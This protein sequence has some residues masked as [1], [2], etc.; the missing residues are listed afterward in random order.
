M[1]ATHVLINI[2]G[3]IALIVWGIHM[4]Q[5]GVMRVFGSDLRRVLARGLRT[6]WHAFAA[7]LGVTTLLQ[8]STATALMAGSLAGTG[9][10]DL[11]TG[12]AIMLG[13]N[14]GTTLIV[15]VLAFDVSVVFPVFLAAGVIAFRRGGSSR[16]HDFGRVL[17][18][19]GLI[20]LALRLLG[21]TIA[22]G[23]HSAAIGSFLAAVTAEPLINLLIAALVT[24]IVAFQC[25]DAAG[26]DVARRIGAPD[27]RGD[28]RD[29]ARR[30]YRQRD[31]PGLR[32]RFGRP[33]EAPPPD[34]KPGDP[35]LRGGGSAAIPRPAGR[36]ACGD[37]AGRRSL[38]RELPYRVQPGAR[39]SLH[40]L[41]AA[42]RAGAARRSCRRGLRRETRPG[43]SIST[44]RR[45][46][47]RRSR[48]PMR[49]AKRCAWST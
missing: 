24:A 13:A 3:Q 1:P 35:R 10:L 41:H 48:W 15:Q 49:S 32:G 7:G 36:A 34:R 45:S 4:V 2:V 37:A 5:T 14:V 43:R 46:A 21:E 17:I 38:R 18:G 31:Q 42:G 44:R 40:R 6:R 29:G 33:V 27:A 39:A 11:S 28:H 26:G 22:P 16:L 12:L 25:G 23:E 47:Y 19:L 8:S 9:A 30:Q 20:L